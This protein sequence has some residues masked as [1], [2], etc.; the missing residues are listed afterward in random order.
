MTAYTYGYN[1]NSMISYAEARCLSSKQTNI[2]E[3]DDIELSQAQQCGNTT[4]LAKRKNVKG[5]FFHPFV[6]SLPIGIF[7]LLK[8]FSQ[9]SGQQLCGK[10]VWQPV[11]LQEGLVA[12]LNVFLMIGSRVV[13][14]QNG[15]VL[16]SVS[17][18]LYI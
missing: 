11:N 1:V 7:Y 18:L 6:A 5:I 17:I 2:Y 10:P 15:N 8:N 4:S 9:G 14:K 3:V 12:L 16:I 13:V